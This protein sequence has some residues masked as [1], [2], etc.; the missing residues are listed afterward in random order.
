MKMDYRTKRIFF[1]L[2]MNY[3]FTTLAITIHFF[4]I[5]GPQL[6]PWFLFTLIPIS[7]VPTTISIYLSYFILMRIFPYKEDK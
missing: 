3:A 7:L 6:H 2:L 4:M 5:W 1:G